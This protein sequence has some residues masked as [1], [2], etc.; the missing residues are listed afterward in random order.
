M[1]SKEHQLNLIGA[2]QNK[3]FFNRLC[4][5]EKDLQ[6]HTSRFTYINNS[7]FCIVH[8]Y[9][10]YPTAFRILH[11][12]RID[13]IHANTCR[14]QMRA[15]NMVK[16]NPQHLRLSKGKGKKM[17]EQIPLS[18][19]LLSWLS[20]SPGTLYPPA[21]VLNSASQEESCRR[22]SPG[23]APWASPQRLRPPLLH[24][25][26]R[27]AQLTCG[28]CGAALTQ[29]Q[30]PPAPALMQSP[31]AADDCVAPLAK[32][33]ERMPRRGKESAARREAAC[34]RGAAGRAGAAGSGAANKSRAALGG[35]SQRPGAE[36][37]Q[38]ASLQPSA[39][40]G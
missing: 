20:I 11:A 6:R 9:P 37:S 34:P 25:C 10:F 27:R 2:Y 3:P 8:I 1:I 38:Q 13:L 14:E 35:F 21:A 12:V 19:Q 17:K 32:R 40:N 33:T 23:W 39:N 7:F 26:C 30:R 4:R 22:R 16:N 29:R 24:W 18:F 28:G 15:K 36:R 5:A 31:A